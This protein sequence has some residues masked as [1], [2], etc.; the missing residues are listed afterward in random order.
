[1]LLL[2]EFFLSLGALCQKGYKKLLPLL[3]I[4]FL[5]HSYSQILPFKFSEFNPSPNKNQGRK[6]KKNVWVSWAGFSRL[7]QRFK[8]SLDIYCQYHC[9][10]SVGWKRPVEQKHS[11][12]TMKKINMC[13]AVNDLLEFLNYWFYRAS[14]KEKVAPKFSTEKKLHLWW[15]LF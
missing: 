13:F 15:V 4:V 6:E 2:L 5:C 1:M 14:E 3:L 7:T 11:I 9:H 10:Y 12:W 8:M